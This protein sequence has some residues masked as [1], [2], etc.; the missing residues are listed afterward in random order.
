MTRLNYTDRQRILRNAVHL[1]VDVVGGLSTLTAS[2][3]L[4]DYSFPKHAAVVLEARRQTTF[5]RFELGEVRDPNSL[6]GE[7]LTEFGGDGSV[8]FTLKVVSADENDIGRILGLAKRLR[9]ASAAEDRE[10]KG[11]LPFRAS[12]DL[13]SRC[14]QLDLTGDEPVVLINRM[15]GDWNGFARTPEFCALVYPELLRGIALW[16]AETDP[17]D[18][19]TSD[20]LK[21]LKGLG[22]DPGGAPDDEE[23][24]SAWAEEVAFSFAGRHHL[25]DLVSEGDRE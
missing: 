8:T 24:R 14:W 11:I 6:E 12:D 13:G 2:V 10:S 20:W 15:V 9:A 5:M 22:H 25:L 23:G 19:A 16:V 7:P 18:D 17:E 1:D 21:F 4:A 3:D